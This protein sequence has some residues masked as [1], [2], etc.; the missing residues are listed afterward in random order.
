MKKILA[1]LLVACTIIISCSKKEDP[2]TVDPALSILV[3]KNVSVITSKTNNSSYTI[4]SNLT[5][6]GNKLVSLTSEGAESFTN[7]FTYTGDL[8]TKSEIIYSGNVAA[9]T[10]IYSYNSSNNLESTLELSVMEPDLEIKKKY[11][12]NSDAT[13]SFVLEETNIKTKNTTTK[14]TGKLYFANGNLTKIEETVGP[15]THVTT[16]EY[17][18]KNNWQKNI[19]GAN[20]IIDDEAAFSVNNV[21]KSTKITS[22]NNQANTVSINSYGLTYDNTNFPTK[23]VYE[24]RDYILTITYTY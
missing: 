5:Y 1:P 16:F 15:S 6:N 20:K 10:T 24:N 19:T 2:V 18:T 4:T 13:V 14:S 17:D 9:K 23:S 3:K 8:I 11:T 22:Y 7:N 12:Y 21:I